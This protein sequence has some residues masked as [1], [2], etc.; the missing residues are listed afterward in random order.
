[1]NDLFSIPNAKK[2]QSSLACI[3]VCI[4]FEP[5]DHQCWA[6][7]TLNDTCL[8]RTELIQP[9]TEISCTFDDSS[10]SINGKLKINL[11]TNAN[12][13]WATAEIKWLKVQQID[14]THLLHHLTVTTE[15]A[16][17]LPMDKPLWTWLVR[18]WSLVLPEV[19]ARYKSLISL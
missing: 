16:V 4:E 17:S 9:Y 15:N 10:T 7:I 2:K 1:M 11:Q 18:N 13:H 14:I 6:E 12:A 5:C 19:Y 8:A 3:E